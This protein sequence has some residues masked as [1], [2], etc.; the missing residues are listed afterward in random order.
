MKKPALRPQ[1][2]QEAP[3]Q[4]HSSW[5]VE[6]RE[7]RPCTL[8]EDVLDQQNRNFQ[9]TAGIS[10]NNRNSG[11]VPAFRNRFS[12]A[13]VIS[14]YLDGRPAPFHL[15]DGLPDSWVLERDSEGHVVRAQ[16]G[17]EAGFVRD[18]LFFTREEAARVA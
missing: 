16:P 4:R 6:P 7:N 9:S 13:F 10:A 1:P 14:C 18:G 5:Q 2:F 15:L 17:V 3:P 8:S 11:Y 12:Q